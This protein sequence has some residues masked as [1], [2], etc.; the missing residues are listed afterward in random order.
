M[1][2]EY[3]LQCITH[4]YVGCR[5]SVAGVAVNCAG[6]RCASFP[7][8]TVREGV[9]K[10]AVRF[11]GDSGVIDTVENGDWIYVVLYDDGGK[12]KM[13]QTEID[14]HLN[15]NTEGHHVRFGPHLH[16][17]AETPTGD[18]SS[19]CKDRVDDPMGQ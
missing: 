18:D 19:S 11:A 9:I 13:S 17:W 5:L 7:D 14:R 8:G 2:P 1:D 16:G 3:L 6:V 12:E 4:P 15:R 10:R